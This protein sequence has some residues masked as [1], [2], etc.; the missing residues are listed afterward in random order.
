[1]ITARSP[2][3]RTDAQNQALHMVLLQYT[4]IEG[5][6]ALAWLEMALNGEWHQDVICTVE[7]INDA[8]QYMDKHYW[9]N[10]KKVVA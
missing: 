2:F 3:K 8:M 5:N 1:M 4:T 6:G 10:M 7:D 9:T